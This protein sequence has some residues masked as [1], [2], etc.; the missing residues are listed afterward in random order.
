M[1]TEEVLKIIV[2]IC[3]N[4]RNARHGIEILLRSGMKANASKMDVLNPE[5]IREVKNEVY[6]ELRSDVFEDLKENELITA[7]SVGRILSK[8]GK[9]ATG[10]NEIYEV[11]KLVCEEYEYKIH[12]L[13]TFRLCLTTLENLGIISHQVGTLDEGTR[14]RRSKISLFDIPAIILVERVENVLKHKN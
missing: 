7:L 8:Q 9:V 4:T 12:S 1:V 11:Y 6:P 3:A 13:S 14:G 5:L 2:D 10:V